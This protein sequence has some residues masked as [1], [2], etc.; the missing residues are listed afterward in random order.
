M[1]PHKGRVSG[2]RGR[3]A[4]AGTRIGIW[5]FAGT[6]LGEAWLPVAC[7][8]GQS[9][10][11]GDGLRA[12]LE[13]KEDQEAKRAHGATKLYHFAILVPSHQALARSVSQLIQSQTRITGAADHLVSEAIYLSDPDGNG[14]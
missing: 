4:H 11:P 12:L 10:A 1:P 13:L 9:A 2:Y 5:I 8:V 7:R 14:I 3:H 6:L